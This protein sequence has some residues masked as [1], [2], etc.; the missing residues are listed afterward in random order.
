MLSSAT[1]SFD[2][3]ADQVKA[4]VGAYVEVEESEADL[5]RF[6]AWLAKI[7][8]RDY[9]TAPAGQA[10]RAAVAACEQALAQFEQAALSAEAPAPDV[11]PDTGAAEHRLQLVPPRQARA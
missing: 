11:H 10:A 9:F 5:D 8:A 1:I 2:P 4:T 7:T 3:V 6:R